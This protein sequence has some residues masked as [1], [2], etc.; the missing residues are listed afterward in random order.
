MKNQYFPNQQGEQIRDLITKLAEKY[1]NLLEGSS[2]SQ[3]YKRNLS[4]IKHGMF[5]IIHNYC[6]NLDI[7]PKEKFPYVENKEPLENINYERVNFL[8]KEKAA[9]N[10]EMV[11]HLVKSTIVETETQKSLEPKGKT[12]QLVQRIDEVSQAFLEYENVNNVYEEKI[13]NIIE[14]ISQ[15]SYECPTSR[16]E[17]PEEIYLLKNLTSDSIDFMPLQKD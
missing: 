12:S 8:K 16:K 1:T 14:F 15:N 17:N 7:E 5:T 13:Q 3:L 2:K 6:R 10:Y 9:E 11:N 4:V